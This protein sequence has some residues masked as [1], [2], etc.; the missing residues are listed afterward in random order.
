MGFVLFVSFVVLLIRV[1]LCF[2]LSCLIWFV[3]LFGLFK[4]ATVF[5]WRFGQVHV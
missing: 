4:A 5:G 3:V 2:V 1:L